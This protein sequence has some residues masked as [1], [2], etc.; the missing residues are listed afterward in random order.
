MVI[1]TLLLSPPFVATVTGP[2]TAPSGTVQ[3]ISVLDQDLMAAVL[4]SGNITSESIPF[5]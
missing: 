1:S 4:P 2:D 5:S 3:T